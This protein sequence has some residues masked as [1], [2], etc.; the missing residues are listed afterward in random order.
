MKKQVAIGG[1]LDKN[2][3]DFGSG[4]ECKP[5][6]PY[7]LGNEFK[8]NVKEEEKTTKYRSLGHVDISTLI[9]FCDRQ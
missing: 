6:L 1:L 8:H 3:H 7:V 2:T 9:L 5:K 4:F